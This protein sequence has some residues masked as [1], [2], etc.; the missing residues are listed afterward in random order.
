[1]TKRT[2][3]NPRWLN[4][5]KTLITCTF[6]YENGMNAQATISETAEGNPDWKEIM[7]T[8][9]TEYLDK[10]TQEHVDKAKK[11]DEFRKQRQKEIEEARKN[12]ILFNAKLEAFTI[13]EIKNSKNTA[14]K[15]RIRKAKSVTEVIALTV[16]LMQN[17]LALPQQNKLVDEPQEII[18]NETV[19]NAV[20]VPSV[21]RKRGRPPKKT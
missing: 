20:E 12:E 17:E 5:S 8:F 13:N 21:Q 9:G 6:E 3:K 15:S 16:L 14:L 7:E 2:I 4:A 1:M 11:Q 19:E 18:E 10:V